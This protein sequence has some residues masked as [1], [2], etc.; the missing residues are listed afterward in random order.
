MTIVLKA[1]RLDTGWTND[2]DGSFSLAGVIYLHDEAIKLRD[3][4][5]EKLKD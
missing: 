3:Y 1:S 4:L 5:V 2:L